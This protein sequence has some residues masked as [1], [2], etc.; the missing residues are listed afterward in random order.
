MFQTI[1]MREDTDMMLHQ[2]I[3]QTLQDHELH[4]FRAFHISI[5]A[6]SFLLENAFY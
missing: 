5:G 3:V 1:T 6:K 4:Y 2:I